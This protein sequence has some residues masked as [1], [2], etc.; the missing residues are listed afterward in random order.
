MKPISVHYSY[1]L[2]AVSVVIS[3]IAAYAA[4]SLA[5]RMRQATNATTRRW[6]LLGGS[7][8]MGIGIWSMHYLGMLA[9]VLPVEVAYFVPTVALSLLMAVI[10]S[11]VV[12]SV[13]SADEL[14]WK[15]LVGGGLLMGAG[16][17]G[18]HYTGMAAM[19]MSAMHHYDPSVVALSLVVAAG[20]SWMALWIGFSLRDRLKGGA[21]LRVAGGAVMGLGIA[22]MHYTAM[23]GVTYTPD[24]MVYSTA[25]TIHVHWLGQAAVA[26]V[27]ALVLAVALGSAALAKRKYRDLEASQQVLL[28]SQVRLLETNEMLSELSIRDGL[29]GLYNRRHFDSVF[30]TEWRRAARGGL[31]LALLM[32]DVDFFKAFNDT[33]GHQHGDDCLREIARVL[34]DQPQRRHDCVARYGGEEFAMILPGATGEA[35][36][37]IGESIR[38][39]VL[40]L[41]MEHEGSSVN[42]FVTLSIGVCSRKPELGEGPEAMLRDA[43]TALYVAKSTGRNRVMMA[44][45]VPVQV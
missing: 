34:E 36:M 8:A 30:D 1:G 2:M 6:W 18:M 12:L 19:R 32:M 41:R 35:A 38:E 22:A 27:T 5:D 39:A 29:T 44:G 43:D 25:W 45:Q 4:F 9:V 23:A 26:I 17:G 37:K 15:Q 14:G 31:P 16:I 13:V 24:A 10:A 42:D 7:V 3:M 40:A 21:W 33:Y 11:A 28:E 20:F